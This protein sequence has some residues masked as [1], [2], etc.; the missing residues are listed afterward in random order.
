MTKKFELYG[1]GLMML[2]HTGAAQAA[3]AEG[4][5]SLTEQIHDHEIEGGFG[6]LM[7]LGGLTLHQL[8]ICPNYQY[9]TIITKSVWRAL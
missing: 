9:N 7:D 4:L 5:L 1:S 3:Q 2:G 6:R 8:Y